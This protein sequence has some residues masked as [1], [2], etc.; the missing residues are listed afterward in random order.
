MQIH[1]G[2]ISLLGGI[3]YIVRGENKLR[4]PLFKRQPSRVRGVL[5]KVAAN[6][7]HVVTLAKGLAIDSL[8]IL[9]LSHLEHIRGLRYPVVSRA[10]EHVF[11][12]RPALTCLHER[13]MGRVGWG[14]DVT[15]EGGGGHWQ[16]YSYW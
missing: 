11:L 16:H 5:V 15:N 9:Q 1:I 6:A 10:V 3:S 4:L 14:L 2:Q 13:E 8:T 7:D 12:D